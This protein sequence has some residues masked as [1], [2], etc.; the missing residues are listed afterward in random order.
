MRGRSSWSRFFLRLS[1]QSGCLDAIGRKPSSFSP[2][3]ARQGCTGFFVGKSPAF[4]NYCN[5]ISI[6][7]QAYFFSCPKDFCHYNT[8]MAKKMGRP[9]IDPTGAMGRVFQIRLTDAE[10]AEYDRA[11]T[12]AGVKLAAWIRDRLSRAAKRE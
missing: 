12:R 1:L 8:R 7:G 9:P 10:R 6:A 11:A 3:A 2:D 5:Y 4:I